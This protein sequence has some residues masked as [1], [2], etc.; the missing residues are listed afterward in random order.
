MTKRSLLTHFAHTWARQACPLA[1]IFLLVAVYSPAYAKLVLDV[2]NPSLAKM[3]IAVPDFIALGPASIN[4]RDLAAILRNDLYMTGLFHIIETPA[5]GMSASAGDPDFR[6]WA[7][8]GAQALVSASY[9]VE[10][11]QLILEA[12]LYDTALQ[13]MDLGKRFVGHVTDHRLMVH[14][15]GD[16]LMEQLT[17][18]LGC[19]STRIAFVG[20]AAPREVYAMDFDGHGLQR[21][22][23]NGSLNLSPEWS[24]DGKN[25]LFTSYMN[26][27]PDL[28]RL[29]LDTMHWGVVSARPGV[30]VSARY[31][32]DGNIVAL[33]S[34]HNGIP[35]IFLITPQGH[36]IKMLTEGRGNDIS[37]TWSPDRSTIAY[38]SDGAGNP[39]IY[40]VP[41]DG[42]RPRRLTHETTYN[43][44]PDWS[45]RG[46]H[47]AFTARI[48]GRFQ[49][50]TIRTD[51]SDFRVLTDK[52]SNQAP[53]WSPD[54]RMIAFG[55]TRDGAP[56][57]YVMDAEGRV[58]APVSPI[59]GKSA[60]WCRARR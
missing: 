34:N 22:T 28:W 12:K 37:P 56:R 17:G 13:R 11:D 39:H 7:A 26:G 46:T 29:N 8:T 49:I 25:I 54:G 43:T 36:I 33:S 42:G 5:G 2:E 19:F 16:R 10:G 31:S 3:P 48:E 40:L 4:G 32:P 58:Q 57:I 52:G 14:K 38:V 9:R 1:L 44:D 23:N 45:P 55:S 18:V 21:L 51:G 60:A 20:A 59:P 47:I 50:C 30:N 35:K 53:A 41:V 27:K 6:A 15:F 24:P